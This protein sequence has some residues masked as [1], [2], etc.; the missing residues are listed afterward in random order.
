MSEYYTSSALF[1]SSSGVFLITTDGIEIIKEEEV[2]DNDYY[3]WVGSYVDLIAN[4][5][6]KEN[7]QPKIQLVATKA[8]PQ[9]TEQIRRA[10]A[11]IL[12][13]TKKQLKAIDEGI[14]FFLVD[15]MMITSS[16]FVT[17]ELMEHLS[18]TLSTLSTNEQLNEKQEE[19]TPT[20]W[21]SVT[22]EMQQQ[23][24]VSV[25][26]V[27]EIQKKVREKTGG[28]GNVDP[29]DVET[30]KKLK[31]VAQQLRGVEQVEITTPNP[32]KDNLQGPI[33]SEVGNQEEEMGHKEVI[34]ELEEMVSSQSAV[35]LAPNSVR[36][37]TTTT[38][39]A[40]EEEDQGKKSEQEGGAIPRVSNEVRT[41]L[42]YFAGKSALLWFEGVPEL[43][44]LVIPQPMAFVQSL[45]TIIS[46]DV[47]ERLR[48]IKGEKAKKEENDIKQ[49]GTLSYET[50]EKIFSQSEEVKFSA[51]Q[52]WQFLIQL[53][54][55]ILIEGKSGEPRIL[56]P[57]LISDKTQETMLK[58][59]ER[60][61]D[62]ISFQYIFEWNYKS[63]SSFHDLVE[64]FTR[65]FFKEGGGGEISQCFSQKIENKT[66]GC[67][68]GVYGKFTVP[69]TSEKMEFTLL[70]YDEG[71]KSN[72]FK[73]MQRLL[74][75]NL[76]PMNQ[77]A[78]DVLR[79]LDKAFSQRYKEL[80]RGLPCE[81]CEK[82]GLR[83][84]VIKLD[85]NLQPSEYEDNCDGF[86]CHNMQPKLSVLFT[87]QGEGSN[88]INFK[89]THFPV[90]KANVAKIM[91]NVQKR[92]L[93]KYRLLAC[94]PSGLLDFVLRAM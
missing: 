14:S 25:S 71:E 32:E 15:E 33:Q 4:T 68:A 62:T 56:V 50:F 7:I 69:H 82:E 35:E 12:E 27:A 93:V 6:A 41:M 83:G 23:V 47:C 49:K 13:M 3:S 52:V 37:A 78:V 10:G 92:F 70:Q 20:E 18:L 53:G 60:R 43:E 84:K 57:S 59:A 88:Y 40:G 29:K 31:S 38:E 45:R 48:K 89:Y 55:A 1:M 46:H 65:L 64:T 22:T 42:R 91:V 77:S 36:I 34:T 79:S 74:R 39:N 94:G 24:V 5:A 61:E 58:R 76:T 11:K 2:K 67:V 54:L 9:T 44:N 51:Q 75:I 86:G 63:L 16:K 28:G 73:S 90:Q 72:S 17:Q 21:F 81:D 30:L 66:L 87:A 80:E 26:E 85:E 8:E 19:R